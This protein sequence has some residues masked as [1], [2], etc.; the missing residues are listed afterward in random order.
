MK[1]LQDRYVK[2]VWQAT[3]WLDRYVRRTDEWPI[4]YFARLLRRARTWGA[5]KLG[6]WPLPEVYLNGVLQRPGSDKGNMVGIVKGTW[7]RSI[8]GEDIDISAFMIGTYPKSDDPSA[9]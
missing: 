3:S 6:P 8:Y 2:H 7:L 9:T 4:R 1:S 5:K